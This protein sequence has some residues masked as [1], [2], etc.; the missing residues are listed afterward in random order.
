MG[1]RQQQMLR[2]GRGRRSGTDSSSTSTATA[3]ATTTTTAA[4]TTSTTTAA[5][6]AAAATTTTTTT[7]TT[8]Q[9][10]SRP[11]PR[12]S[13]EGPCGG[14]RPSAS[15]EGHVRRQGMLRQS[16][17]QEVIAKLTYGGHASERRDTKGGRGSCRTDLHSEKDGDKKHAERPGLFRGVQ[18]QRKPHGNSGARSTS[19]QI[20]QDMA[21][22]GEN[23]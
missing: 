21:S 18:M 20:R 13:V 19:E 17:K 3:A 2:E 11:T 22:C 1:K 10:T 7:T 16:A 5:A 23:R 12:R 15:P 14:G 4:S 9:P 6:A 8:A